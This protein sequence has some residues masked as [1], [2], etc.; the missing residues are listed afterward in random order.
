LYKDRSFDQ[1][2]VPAP[3]GSDYVDFISGS[4]AEFCVNGPVSA[5]CLGHSGYQVPA[6]PG[7]DPPGGIEHIAA[8][9]FTYVINSLGD[10]CSGRM[11]PSPRPGCSRAL[12]GAWTGS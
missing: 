11:R 1:E 12:L 3:T 9:P 8:G 4:G 2:L 7:S 10:I 6:A 5:T